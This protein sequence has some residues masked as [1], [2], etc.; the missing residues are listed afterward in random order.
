MSIDTSGTNKK[1]HQE[2]KIFFGDFGPNTFPRNL[3][4]EKDGF[5]K[6]WGVWG[7]RVCVCVCVCDGG[8]WNSNSVPPSIGRWYSKASPTLAGGSRRSGQRDG[9]QGPMASNLR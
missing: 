9:E 5:K 2:A 7:V 8:V 4:L 6:L 3:N 1:T